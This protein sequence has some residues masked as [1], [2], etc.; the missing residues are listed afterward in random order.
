ML[1]IASVCALLITRPHRVCL[2]QKTIHRVFSG[3]TPQCL[4]THLA[5][6]AGQLFR[7][8]RG[9]LC[10]RARQCRGS[11][12]GPS[13]HDHRPST[14]RGVVLPCQSIRMALR[15]GRTECFPSPKPTYRLI[16]DLAP[17]AVLVRPTYPRR[18]GLRTPANHGMGFTWAFPHE[19]TFF[20]VP[21]P[22]RNSVPRVRQEMPGFAHGLPTR[23]RLAHPTK[24]TTSF[25]H[26]CRPSPVRHVTTG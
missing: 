6:P 16:S 12:H 18:D 7:V 11:T 9:G 3:A 4:P 17:K 5:Q 2:S 23:T 19:T 22:R 15:R 26:L 21:S 14:T 24:K 13:P 1:K 25:A 20:S 10:T 8:S